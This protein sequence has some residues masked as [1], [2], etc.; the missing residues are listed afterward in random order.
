MVLFYLREVFPGHSNQAA[1]AQSSLSLLLA[2]EVVGERWGVFDASRRS[3][4]GGRRCRVHLPRSGRFE[5]VGDLL[6]QTGYVP[7]IRRGLAARNPFL[8][9]QETPLERKQVLKRTEGNR[10]QPSSQTPRV[11]E[12]EV[13]SRQATG[14]VG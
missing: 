10:L 9:I 7:L 14:V 2:R 6:E 13:A 5:F 8:L 4:L 3:G 1:R 12:A 11:G